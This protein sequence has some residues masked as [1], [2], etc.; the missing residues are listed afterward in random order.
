MKKNLKHSINKTNISENKKY[1]LMLSLGLFLEYKG[2]I[3]IRKSN[4]KSPY[5]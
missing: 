4:Y 5:T 1:N 3:Y 2:S